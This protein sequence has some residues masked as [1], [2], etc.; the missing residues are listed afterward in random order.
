[1]EPTRMA[2]LH[3]QEMVWYVWTV[4]AALV[5]AGSALGYLL[6]IDGLCTLRGA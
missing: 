6:G 4:S 2:R 3:W 5:V 1:M